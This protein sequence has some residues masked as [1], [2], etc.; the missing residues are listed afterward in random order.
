MSI[1]TP[2]RKVCV[3]DP[4]RDLC[5]GCGRTRAEI[6][7]WLSMTAAERRHIMRQLPARLEAA[8]SP[9]APQVKR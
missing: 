6:A 1:V 8:G 5:E 9:A 3:L 4:L 7:S 2:C